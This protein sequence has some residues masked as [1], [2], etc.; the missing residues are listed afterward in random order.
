MLI[1]IVSKCKAFDI[2]KYGRKSIQF[3]PYLRTNNE[4]IPPV[5]INKSFFYI[6]KQY[7]F[8]INPGKI[9]DTMDVIDSIPLHPRN[10]M[11]IVARYDY[12]KL[13]WNLSIFELSKTCT[14]QNLDSTVKTY[15]K[16][17]LDLYRD[18]SFRHLQLP[19]K[20]FGIKFLLS[21]DIYR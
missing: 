13:R 18:A 9:K 6:G 2:R 10:K 3:K 14:I 1:I 4:L 17:W 20:K 5:K 7:S 16:S 21:S 19:I 11:M 8:G 15:V 12:S